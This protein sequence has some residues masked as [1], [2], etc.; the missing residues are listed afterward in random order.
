VPTSTVRADVSDALALADAAAGAPRSVASSCRTLIDAPGTSAEAR[1]I[2]LRALA[3]SLRLLEQHAEATRMARRSVSLARRVGLPERQHE[4]R[5]TL[6]LCLFHLGRTRTALEQVE[7]VR[8]EA[9][10]VLRVRADIQ[11]GI[12]LERLGRL[13]DAVS[14]YTRALD[15][16]GDELDRARALN[17]RAIALTFLGRTDQ[18]LHDLDDAVEL[19]TARGERLLAGE[20]VHNIGFTLAADGDIAGALRRFDEADAIFLAHDAPIGWNLADR[21]RVLLG[22]NLHQEA[23]DAA[24]RAV[25]VLLAGGAGADVAE[26]R[27]LLAEAHL[28]GGELAE[29][30][31]AAA[32][33]RR[34][35]VRQGRPGLAAVAQLMSVRA[36][37]AAGRRDRRL[38]VSAEQ[39]VAD[40]VA[41]GLAGA[42]L[43]ARMAAADVARSVGESRVAA[44]HLAVVS[45]HRSSGPLVDR[46][47]GWHAE[48]IR[49]A[50]AGARPTARRAVLAG[51][52]VLADLQATVGASELRASVAGH[53]ADLAQL[54]VRLALADRSPWAVLEVLE[55]WR[56]GGL[57]LGTEASAELTAE[58]VA[59]RAARTRLE[60]AE[61]LGEDVAAAQRAVLQLEQV[62]RDRLRHAP[63]V[64]TAATSPLVR[65]DVAARLGDR[66]LVSY[67][68]SDGWIGAVAMAGRRL[69]LSWPLAETKHVTAVA[70][71]VLFGL[72]RLAR[73]HRS[74]STPAARAAVD[75]GLARLEEALLAPLEAVVGDRPLVAVPT[76]ALHALPWSFLPR[77][78]DRPVTVTPS[79]RVWLARAA[80]RI[81]GRVVLVAGPGLV[82]ADAEV[83]ALAGVHRQPVVLTGAAA[84]V[85]GVAAALEGASMTHLACHGRFRTDNPLFS[86]L[87]LADGP[88][89]VVDIE[90]LDQPPELIL[91][92]AC[93]VGASSVLAGDQL[94]GVVSALLMVGTSSVVASLLPVPDAASVPFMRAVHEQLAAG[95]PAA[96]ALVAGRKAVDVDDPAGFVTGAAFTC[97][98]AG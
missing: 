26:A 80:P 36:R 32:A 40:L 46:V 91:L 98:G 29:A 28:A 9:A 63:G 88:V 22:A 16:G 90:R 51:L 86:S 50:D 73:P 68:E 89:T 44:R 87:A 95:E 78:R 55:R 52:D 43:A 25:Q 17:N 35:L 53:G 60:Q 14:A 30:G 12:I 58:L 81:D 66:A 83:A 56:G 42:E 69:T 48:A 84:T 85:T 64:V 67:F 13:D 93:E 59:L 57:L 5:L 34:A 74:S 24:S 65:A 97:Y 33:A 79:L 6:S 3:L 7:Q 96:A 18:A 82:H 19:A 76:G 4:A 54:G 92:A 77:R 37:L 71:S 70:D 10:D 11:H 45:R 41:A 27:L 49:R 21:A 15:G 8:D 75:T 39:A 1:E 23:V 20:F 47:R 38:L 72:R 2:A 62:V 61:Q 94:L 31:A